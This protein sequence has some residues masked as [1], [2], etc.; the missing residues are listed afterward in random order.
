[1]ATQRIADMT[2]AE[3]NKVIDEAIDRRLQGLLKPQDNRS[4]A[5]LLKELDKLR[6]TPPEGTKST[7]ELL[8]EDRDA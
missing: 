3:L 1:M 7:L 5:E 2:L 6:F 8:R 4:N